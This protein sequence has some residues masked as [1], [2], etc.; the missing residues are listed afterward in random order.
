MAEIHK[1]LDSAVCFVAIQKNKGVDTGLGGQRSLEKPRLYLAMEAGVL[2]IVKAKNWTT[3]EN[4]NG[5]Q[6]N[7]KLVR[8]CKFLTQNSWYLPE[9]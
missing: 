2:K 3:S 4:P 1:K 5:K 6:I 8:G 9:E 7:F